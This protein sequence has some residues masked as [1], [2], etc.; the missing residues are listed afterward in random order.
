MAKVTRRE[1]ADLAPV[2]PICTSGKPT[3]RVYRVAN[4][5]HAGEHYWCV[6]NIYGAPVRNGH[7]AS[8]AEAAAAA[9]QASPTALRDDNH[10]FAY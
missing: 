2:C 7:T 9:M 1:D 10:P 8:D 5:P 6:R 3:F 4:G